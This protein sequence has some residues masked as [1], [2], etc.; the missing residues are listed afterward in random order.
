MNCL[1]SKFPRVYV[2][3][4][5]KQDLEV[6]MEVSQA[7][8]LLHVLRKKKGDKVLLFNG[9]EGVWEAEIFETSPKKTILRCKKLRR[10]QENEP[11]AWL[12]FPP[13]K[14]EPLGFLLEKATEL[15]VSELYP[16]MT[17]YAETKGF[18][19]SK[20]EARI[21][22]AAEQCERLTVPPIHFLR[23]LAEALEA[24]P[25]GRVLY[26]CVER[27]EAPALLK[28]LDPSKEAAFLVGPEGGFSEKDLDLLTG[29]D[30][31]RFVSLGPL[32]LRAETAGVVVLGTYGQ[33]VN[34]EK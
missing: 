33:R 30:F 13:L 7:H 10:P 25:E 19:A 28:A 29:Y 31:V 15:G 24:W 8:Y 16:I 26:A 2:S 12:L 4:P 6:I 21:I 27:K 34:L 3:L 14:K 32:I 5:L 1:K 17:E 11:G 18:S 20:A 22:E 23:P 9:L